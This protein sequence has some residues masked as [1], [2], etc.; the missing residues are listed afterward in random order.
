MPAYEKAI[1]VKIQ[2]AHDVLKIVLQALHQ[3]DGLKLVAAL[4][5]AWMMLHD[6]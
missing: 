1:P 5:H 6:G 4:D 3:I 2:D